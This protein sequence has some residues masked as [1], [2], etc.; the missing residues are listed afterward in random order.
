MLAAA[1]SVQVAVKQV[2]QQVGV[3]WVQVAVTWVQVA[4]MWAQVTV[5]P[6]VVAVMELRQEGSVVAGEEEFEEVGLPGC[7]QVQLLEPLVL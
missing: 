4:V 7:L 3:T 6:V 2:Q 5:I 1:K